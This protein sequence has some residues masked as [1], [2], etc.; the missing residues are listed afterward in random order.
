[1]E[2]D[3]RAFSRALF[4]GLNVIAGEQLTPEESEAFKKDFSDFNEERF[5]AAVREIADF[6]AKGSF[7]IV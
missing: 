2:D 1:M 5:L 6:A 3:A 7:R 4:R